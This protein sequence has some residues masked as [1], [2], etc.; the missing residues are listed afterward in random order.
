GLVADVDDARRHVAALGALLPG[1]AISVIGD[2][3]TRLTSTDHGALGLAFA[4]SLLLS[5]W[6]ANAGMKALIDGLNVAYET[7]ETR[8]FLRLNAI[9]LGFTCGAIV[10]AVLALGV[11]VAAPG[12]APALG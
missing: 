7:H 11:L 12:L 5:I 1:G 4:I 8:G 3:L 10:L 2:E 6:S 9:S